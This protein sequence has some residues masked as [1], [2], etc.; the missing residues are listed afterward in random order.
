MASEIV[1]ILFL[2]KNVGL[3]EFLA[4]CEAPEND[5][6]VGLGRKLGTAFSIDAGR[7]SKPGRA[8]PRKLVPLNL[9]GHATAPATVDH[10]FAHLGTTIW[11]LH[12]Q[13]MWVRGMPLTA[14]RL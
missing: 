6:P 11:V 13:G 5:R 8:N 2:L 7:R 12:P 1:E 10:S 14:G 3:G 9:I 4:A